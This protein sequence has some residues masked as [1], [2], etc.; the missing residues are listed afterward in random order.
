MLH[1]DIKKAM[2]DIMEFSKSHKEWAE[3][4][5]KYPEIEK[6]YLKTGEWDSANKHREIIKKY[7][8]IA[9]LLMI[10]H[11]IEKV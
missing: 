4:F 8:H 5:E 10:L 7:E 6:K 3:F 2:K 9:G 1:K 11:D